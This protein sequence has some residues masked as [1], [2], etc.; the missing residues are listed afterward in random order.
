MLVNYELYYQLQSP[1]LIIY[2]PLLV[3]FT[4]PS[5]KTYIYL[6]H[7]YD[8]WKFWDQ[9]SDLYH[10]CDSIHSSDNA[11][12]LCHWGTPTFLC[13]YSVNQYPLISSQIT[14][15]SISSK[16]DLLMMDSLKQ[17]LLVWQ[18]IPPFLNGIFVRYSI[19]SDF[20]A[21]MF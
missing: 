13:F 5:Y 4:W 17:I 8:I 1:N 15:F 6:G 12:S 7:T 11:G 10:S 2:L 21:P 14:P 16:A 18:G 3:S 19:L 20:F 9:E